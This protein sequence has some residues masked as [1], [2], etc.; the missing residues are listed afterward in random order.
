MACRKIPYA[1]NNTGGPVDVWAVEGI[2][3]VRL[4]TSPAGYL[5]LPEPISPD[6]LAFVRRDISPPDAPG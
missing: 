2:D 6:R 5:Y 1:A 3:E 4:L